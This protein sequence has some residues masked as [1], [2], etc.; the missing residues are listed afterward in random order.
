[1]KVDKPFENL[2][3]EDDELEV[4]FEWDVLLTIYIG[5]F[6]Q[7][8]DKMLTLKLLQDQEDLCYYSQIH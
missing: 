4:H 3:V 1:M 8:R 2:K 7:H 6:I 5:L